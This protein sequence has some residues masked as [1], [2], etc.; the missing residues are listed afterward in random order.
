MA[1]KNTQK[2]SNIIMKPSAITKCEIGQDWY[3]HDFEIDFTPADLY[4]DYMEEEA[5]IME[6]IDGKELNIE[7]AVNILYEHL[8]KVYDPDKLQITDYIAGNK[9]HFDVIVKK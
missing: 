9:V 2:I 6:N 1:L 7:D 3:K 5:W 4:P 8:E